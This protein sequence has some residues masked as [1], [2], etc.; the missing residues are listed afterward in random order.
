MTESFLALAAPSLAASLAGLAGA[1]LFGVILRATR[2]E[3]R[4]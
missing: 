1:A 4:P 2:K 3:I